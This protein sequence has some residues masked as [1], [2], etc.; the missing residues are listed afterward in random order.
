MKSISKRDSVSTDGRALGISK[1]SFEALPSDPVLLPQVPRASEA[2]CS[3][4]WW[5]ACL[6]FAFSNSSCLVMLFVFLKIAPFYLWANSLLMSTYPVICYYV[7]WCIY[8]VSTTY[9]CII[10][11]PSLASDMCM[12]SCEH[13][14]IHPPHIYGHSRPWIFSGSTTTDSLHLSEE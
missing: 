8:Y 1:E 7:G 4:F 9:A 3:S 14:S 6:T 11:Q 2:S 12:Y 10:T 5:W 13:V